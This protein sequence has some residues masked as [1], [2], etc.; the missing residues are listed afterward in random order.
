MV[1]LIAVI[2]ILSIYVGLVAMWLWN[3]AAV[4]LFHAPRTGFLQAWAL[5]GLLALVASFFKRSG[6]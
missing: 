6:K 4:P 1:K 5:C 2:V 3:Y